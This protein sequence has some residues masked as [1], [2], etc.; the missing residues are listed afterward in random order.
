MSGSKDQIQRQLQSISDRLKKY[1][2]NKPRA[3]N[4]KNN[5]KRRNRRNRGFK[6]NPNYRRTIYRAPVATGMVVNTYSRLIPNRAGNTARLA[7]CE[8]FDPELTYAPDNSLTWT[9]AINP[10]KWT[11][12]RTQTQ[13]LLYSQFR[14]EYINIQYVPTCGTNTSGTISWGCLYNS[15]TIDGQRLHSNLTQCE[16]GALTPVWQSARSR[17]RCSTSLFQ[18]YFGLSNASIQDIPITLIASQDVV[19]ST[20]MEATGYFI[21][22]GVFRLSGPRTAPATTPF[23][24][25]L[26]GKFVYDSDKKTTSFE[27]S[28]L[29]H[30][31]N[32]KVGDTFE[33]KIVGYS[34][35][36]DG[37]AY[38]TFANWMRNIN[39]TVTTVGQTIQFATSLG[40]FLTQA[41]AGIAGLSLL[42]YGKSPDSVNF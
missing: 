9:L 36:P 27:S 11:S 38:Q 20:T 6:R 40:N 2:A 23:G 26:Q 25:T 42:I 31:P 41:S 33:A 1:E 14:P 16:G 13:S 32:V 15:A 8:I 3:I 18:N 7:F 29:E 35:N 37:G 4:T 5:Q 28:D 24:G 12:T 34:N 39:L 22:S 19:D 10:A 21:I 17:V 30:L